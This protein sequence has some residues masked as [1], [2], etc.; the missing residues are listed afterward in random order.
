MNTTSTKKEAK[1]PDWLLK[2]DGIT[3]RQWK[4]KKRMELKAVMDS[5]STYQTGCF[6]TPSQDGQVGD[7]TRLLDDLKELQSVKRWGR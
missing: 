6:Y 4:T 3:Q 5:F 1:A 2:R 7:I